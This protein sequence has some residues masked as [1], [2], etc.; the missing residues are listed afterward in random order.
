MG[1]W[2]FGVLGFWWGVGSGNLRKEVNQQ[3]EKHFPD[4]VEPFMIQNQFLY[5]LAGTGVIGLGL[6]ILGFVFPLV[7]QKNY[8]HPLIFAFGAM[9][10]TAWMI[11]HAI[12]NAVGVAH[13][14]FFLLVLLKV[15]E[16]DKQLSRLDPI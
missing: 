6:T 14:L 7:Y 11:E 12:E 3:Y 16:R 15:L 1:F 4:Y 13:Y 9:M 2:G 10:L 8:L 5:A